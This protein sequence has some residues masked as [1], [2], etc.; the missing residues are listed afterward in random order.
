MHRDETG[1]EIWQ[2]TVGSGQHP[3]DAFAAA[4]GTGGTISGISECLKAKHC[5][6]HQQQ[7]WRPTPKVFLVDSEIG[8][9]NAALVETGVFPVSQSPS[10]APELSNG[11]MAERVRQER[12]LPRLSAAMNLADAVRSSRRLP[13]GSTIVTILPDAATVEELEAARCR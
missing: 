13:R 4:S 10:P 3:L 5:S 12:V 1:E 8:S 2:A 6:D 11:T 7:R 9:G